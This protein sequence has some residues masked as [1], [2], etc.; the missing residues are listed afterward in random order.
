MQNDKSNCS[1]WYNYVLFS[2]RSC[3]D[4]T[5]QTEL[6]VENFILEQQELH[7]DVSCEIVVFAINF[8]PI[9]KHE[10]DFLIFGRK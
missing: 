7:S 3:I 1:F 10:L 4:H 5:R 6:R 2:T 8:A 9:W